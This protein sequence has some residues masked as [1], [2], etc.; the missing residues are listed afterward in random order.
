METAEH[1]IAYTVIIKDS[2][3]Q[4]NFLVQQEGNTYSFPAA[5]ATIK[6]TALACVINKVKDLLSLNV[7]NL[8]LT[9]LTNAVVHENRIPLYV[10]YYEEPKD[11]EIIKDSDKYTWVH[12]NELKSTF[13]EWHIGGAPLLSIDSNTLNIVSQ[14]G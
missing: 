6:R 8:E 4:I 12:Y 7:D 3:G 10:F 9:E 13:N 11:L 5:L 14:E 2:D 1:Y